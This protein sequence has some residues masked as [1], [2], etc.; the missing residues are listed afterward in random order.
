[1]RSENLTT[2]QVL[3]VF[4]EELAARGGRVTDTFHD[5]KRLFTRAVLPEVKD[6][7]PGD[8]LQ[9][10]VALKYTEEQIC[11]YPYIFRLVCRNGAIAAETI[12]ARVIDDLPQ[13]DPYTTIQT[14]REGIETCCAGEVF[15][16]SVHKMRQATNAR[17]DHVLNVLQ[18]VARHSDLLGGRLL[19]DIMDRFFKDKDRTQFGLANAITSLARDTRDPQTRWN[20]EELGGGLLIAA[21]TKLPEDSARAKPRGRKLAPVA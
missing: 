6:V 8:R 21:P 19:N 15:T 17:V 16:S 14:I 20:L 18:F 10:G 9:G 2:E 5:G 12:A 3:D 7:R 1:M 13:L 4:T 11:I